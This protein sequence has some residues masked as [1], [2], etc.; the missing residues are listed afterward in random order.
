M[1]T[2]SKKADQ[3]WMNPIKECRTSR[4]S[5]RQ[6][7]EEYDIQAAS[8]TR[9]EDCVQTPAGLNSYPRAAYSIV[10]YPSVCHAAEKMWG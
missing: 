4:L 2:L 1:K 9:Y 7:C 3:E 6:W 5:D 10:S 8:T